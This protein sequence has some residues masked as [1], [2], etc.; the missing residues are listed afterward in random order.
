MSFD[1]TL[2]ALVASQSQVKVSGT[3]AAGN[4]KDGKILPDTGKQP[5][6]NNSEA[7]PSVA[8][9]ENVAKKLNEFV[10]SHQYSVRFSVDEGSGRHIIKV[11]DTNTDEVIRQ[12]PNQQAL[13]IAKAIESALDEFQATDSLI[14]D[15]QA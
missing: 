14:L 7:N 11:V 13:S 3:G 8:Q 9:L 2:S 1:M 5:P 6:Q 12:V 15:T 4:A 10:E